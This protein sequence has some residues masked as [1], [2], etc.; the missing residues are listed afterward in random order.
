[1]YNGIAVFTPRR[2]FVAFQKNTFSDEIPVPVPYATYPGGSEIPPTLIIPFIVYSAIYPLI[3]LDTEI[4]VPPIMSITLPLLLFVLFSKK[5]IVFYM[6]PLTFK[7]PIV[8]F[9]F[10][11]LFISKSFT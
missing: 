4:F 1:L 3:F 11:I 9:A 6:F 10:A 2:L 5:P 7:L 8:K